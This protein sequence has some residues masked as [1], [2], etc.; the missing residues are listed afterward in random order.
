MYISWFNCQNLIFTRKYSFMKGKM[1]LFL[2]VLFVFAPAF[3]AKV[4]TVFCVQYQ[5]EQE[6]RLRGGKTGRV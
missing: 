3:A 5:H 1:L 2:A 6:Y 4:D